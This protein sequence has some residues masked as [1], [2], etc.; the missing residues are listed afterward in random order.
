MQVLSHRM[1]K[2]NTI[3]IEF[4]SG[5]SYGNL[6]VRFDTSLDN[7]TFEVTTSITGYSVTGLPFEEEQIT[8]KGDTAQIIDETPLGRK[9][10]PTRV[11][12]LVY[13]VAKKVLCPECV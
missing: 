2:D 13:R 6:T 9:V 12:W 8:L 7:E 11:F 1:F 4:I 3:F 5:E 10:N